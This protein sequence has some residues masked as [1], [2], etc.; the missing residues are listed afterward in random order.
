MTEA[1]HIDDVLFLCTGSLSRS[2][3]AEAILN[4]AGP[5]KFRGTTR[6]APKVA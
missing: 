5:G 3:T 2:I 1:T 6:P 4:K